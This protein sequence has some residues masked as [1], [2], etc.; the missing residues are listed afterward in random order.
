MRKKQIS[1]NQQIKE[2][3]RKLFLEKGFD[4][5]SIRDIAEAAHS[6]VAL[7][8]YY[9]RSKQ[10]LFNQIVADIVAEILKPA[11]SI[12]QQ[13][14]LSVND[15]MDQLVGTYTDYFNAHPEYP[16]FVMD[17]IHRDPAFVLSLIP[18]SE[19]EQTPFVSQLPESMKESVGGVPYYVHLIINALSMLLLPM[20]V[21]PMFE[22]DSRLGKQA[23]ADLSAI[24]KQMIPIWINTM[25][26]MV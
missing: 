2:S 24:R 7:L 14:G 18:V 17:E 19:L 25:V 11:L 6:N 20:F 12:F 4:A 5:T 8:N 9:F 1:T 23:F 3:A 10:G 13:E 22:A 26:E 21:K 16:V 15:A